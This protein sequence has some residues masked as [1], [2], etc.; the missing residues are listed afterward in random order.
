MSMLFS[1][2][3]LKSTLYIY[4]E[5]SN[6]FPLNVLLPGLLLLMVTFFV[7]LTTSTTGTLRS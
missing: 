6:G 1:T 4:D 3:L 7:S 2:E 5:P